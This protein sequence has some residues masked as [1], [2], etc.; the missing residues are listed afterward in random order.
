MSHTPRH[1][2]SE[3]RRPLQERIAE[4]KAWKQR[5]ESILAADA[6]LEALERTVVDVSRRLEA[7]ER[8]P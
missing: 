4:Q 6:R 3:P 1:N 5:L 2:K 8:R 7:Q